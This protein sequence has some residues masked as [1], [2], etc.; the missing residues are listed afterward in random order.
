MIH[1]H[2]IGLLYWLKTD[3]D[4]RFLPLNFADVICVS[5]D[6]ISG[7][8]DIYSLHLDSR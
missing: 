8:L 7:R 2:V 6:S 3:C 5:H 1:C 4:N